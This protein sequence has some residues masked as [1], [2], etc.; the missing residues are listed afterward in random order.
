MWLDIT[1]Q[2]LWKFVDIYCLQFL[3][4]F[5][6]IWNR[7]NQK[8]ELGFW[9]QQAGFWFSII[10]TVKIFTSCKHGEWSDNN[11]AG[12]SIC[13]TRSDSFR[14]LESLGGHKHGLHLL[15]EPSY[16]YYAVWK[17]NFHSTAAP[18]SS[19]GGFHPE[20][21]A[22]NHRW[23]ISSKL[24]GACSHPSCCSIGTGSDSMPPVQ[25]VTRSD[26]MPTIH[27]GARLDSIYPNSSGLIP[28]QPKLAPIPIFPILN[29]FLYHLA[30]PYIWPWWIESLQAW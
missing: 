19:T 4:D 1:M 22:H 12:P 25:Q 16:K 17:A 21:C 14:A 26:S 30:F 2:N 8:F 27:Q 10:E 18:R 7:Q 5:T 29:E 23:S 6:Y 3:V 11:I 15:L 20:V 9:N 28:A 24:I 13:A